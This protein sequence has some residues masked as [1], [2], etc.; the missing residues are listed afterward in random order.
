[1]LR[2]KLFLIFSFIFRIST[3]SK[4]NVNRIEIKKNNLYYNNYIKNYEE[5]NITLKS[6]SD[7][8]VDIYTIITAFKDKIPIP[9]DKYQ[10]Y[11]IDSG[12]SGTYRIISGN[13]VNVGNDGIIY[14]KNHTYYWYGNNAFLEPIPGKQPSSVTISYTLGQSKISVNVGTNTYIIIVNVK[15]YG[16]ENVEGKLD[17][18]IKANVANKK[19]KL[20][21]L[22]AITTFPAL[23][24]YDN[25][26][27]NYLAMIIFEK[28]NTAGSSDLIYHLCEKV[29]IKCHVRK[30]EN[31]EG[32]KGGDQNIVAFID[33][34]YYICDL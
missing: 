22:K 31:D 2:I 10:I 23:F 4:A 6:S 34:K 13:S 3:N 1:M 28:G 29:G 33:E 11:K 5:D 7:I 27:N 12:Y 24:P 17:A 30:A 18:Y 19:T 20:D 9:S 26:Y 8:T 25:S 32:A 21:K 15:D 16:S 14:P